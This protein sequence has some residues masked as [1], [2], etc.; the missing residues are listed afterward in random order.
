MWLEIV[1]GKDFALRTVKLDESKSEGW[2]GMHNPIESCQVFAIPSWKSLLGNVSTKPQSNTRIHKTQS[3]QV[4][5][6]LTVQPPF[7]LKLK[8]H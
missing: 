3:Y 8:L 1:F 4:Q 2:E 7:P 5:S 6:T